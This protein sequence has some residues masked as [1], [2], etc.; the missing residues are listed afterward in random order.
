VFLIIGA[1]GVGQAIA[2]RLHEVGEAVGLLHRPYQKVDLPVAC[3]GDTEAIPWEAVSTVFLCT[4]DSQI[5]PTAAEI[6]PR[7][8]AHA[9]M[10]H[11]AGSVPLSI[12]TEQIGGRAGVIYPLQSFVPGE[13]VQWGSFPAFWEGHPETERLAHRLTGDPTQVHF[14]D[15][16]ARLR[17]HIGAVFTANFLN[18]LF[19][20]AERLVHPLSDRRI[21]LPLVKTILQRLHHLPPHI[22][23]TGPAR[24]GDFST[25]QKHLALLEDYYPDLAPIYKLLTAYIQAHISVQQDKQP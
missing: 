22:T 15:S 11:T 2:R 17:L 4:K 3:W 14:A 25:I 12:L 23:Q 5:A 19:H 9:L 6:A 1:G 20:I 8:P 13:K 24:R 21:Y 10:I 16:E 18:A 7:L